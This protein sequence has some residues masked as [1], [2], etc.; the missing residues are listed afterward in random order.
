MSK[1]TSDSF[2]LISLIRGTLDPVILHYFKTS[3]GKAWADVTQH[4]ALVMV[5][6]GKVLSQYFTDD[7]IDLS[8]FQPM[9]DDG[10]L[11]EGLVHR[12][13]VIDERNPAK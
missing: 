11:A 6:R 1:T 12:H 9:I 4:E 3:T 10:Q 8:D 5:R 2:S 13:L 7:E